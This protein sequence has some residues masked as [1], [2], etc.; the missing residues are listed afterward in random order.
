MFVNLIQLGKKEFKLSRNNYFRQ[1]SGLITHQRSP[2]PQEAPPDC[3][4]LTANTTSPPA[5]RETSIRP[6]V[7]SEQHPMAHVAPSASA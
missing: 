2:A 6:V 5:P 4:H 7:P 3:P 1:R